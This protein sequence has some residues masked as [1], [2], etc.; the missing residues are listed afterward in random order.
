MR[1]L[2]SSHFS[3]KLKIQAIDLSD[4]DKISEYIKY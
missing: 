4:L 3:K 2:N 1:I